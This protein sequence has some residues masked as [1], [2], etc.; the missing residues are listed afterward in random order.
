MMNGR[1]LLDG[2]DIRATF[3]QNRQHWY[4]VCV[5]LSE[6]ARTKTRRFVLA[7]TMVRSGRK[8]CIVALRSSGSIP[9]CGAAIE[10]GSKPGERLDVT[11]Q[12]I[13][14]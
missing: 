11:F 9:I 8:I 4:Q 3:E 5:I 2:A 10:Q 7:F 14:L 13:Q 6:L 1:V 12:A